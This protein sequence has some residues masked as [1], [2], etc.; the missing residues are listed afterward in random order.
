MSDTGT[1]LALEPSTLHSG[2]I[3]QLVHELR[4]PLGGI[5]SLAY[6]LELALEDGDNELRDQCERIR[7]LVAQASWLLEDASLAASADEADRSAVDLNALVAE[8]GERLARHE[9]RS[10]RLALAGNAPLVWGS[11]SALCAWLRHALSYFRDLAVG[12]PMPLVETVEQDRGV[13]LRVRSLTHGQASLR[14]L[15]PPGGMGGLRRVAEQWGGRFELETSGG[16]VNVG[17]W[18][19]VAGDAFD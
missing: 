15:D 17:L 9:E 16:A 8:T 6:F 2:V 4:Q 3:S 5:E 1:H 10:L 18:L 11:K 13:W 7:Q 12:E 19:P 14:P